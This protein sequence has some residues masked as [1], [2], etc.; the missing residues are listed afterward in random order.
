MIIIEVIDILNSLNGGKSDLELEILIKRIIDETKNLSY[1]SKYKIFKKSDIEYLLKGEDINLYTKDCNEIAVFIVTLSIDFEKRLKYYEKI[2]KL[3]YIV[4]DCVC[5]HLIEEKAELLQNE[6]KEILLKNNKY[7]LNRFSPGYGDFSVDTNADIS[8]I[9][10]ANKMGVFL[11]DKNMFIPSKT[12]SAI[13]ASGDT[14]KYF[15]FCKTCN[16][17]KTCELIKKGK[18]CYE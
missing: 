12:I 9:L 7:M 10:E 8:K 2:D 16:L 4:Y 3:A 17:T 13:I 11:T 6:I 14:V 15:N 1:K 5:S 18:R